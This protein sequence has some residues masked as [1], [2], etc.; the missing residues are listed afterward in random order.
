M[1]FNG[2]SELK[3]RVWQQN[4]ILKW[5]LYKMMSAQMRLLKNDFGKSYS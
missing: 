4:C 3:K 2:D 5:D 1:H